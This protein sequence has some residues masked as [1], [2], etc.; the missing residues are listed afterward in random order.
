MKPLLWSFALAVVACLLPVSAL[1]MPPAT[2]PPPQTKIIQGTRCVAVDKTITRN[3]TTF[4]Q[5][6]W[7][8]ANGT[9][10][11]RAPKTG[12]AKAPEAPKPEL[13]IELPAFDASSGTVT[14]RVRIVHSAED[15]AS[16]RNGEILVADKTLP[17]WVPLMMRAKAI[18][19]NNGGLVSHAAIVARELG[20]PAIVGTQNAT[21]KL[22]DGMTVTVDGQTGIIYEGDAI[23]PKRQQQSLLSKDLLDAY[24]LSWASSSSGYVMGVAEPDRIRAA[25]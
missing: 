7:V 5:R 17:D 15:A 21:T 14:G 6:F 19:T 25:A 18:V 2:T 9:Q 8:K 23:A 22:R 12:A 3:G 11:D 10:N 16:F 13:A 24:A 20:V 4:T 1:A